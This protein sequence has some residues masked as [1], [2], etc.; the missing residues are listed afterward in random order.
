MNVVTPAINV[1]N[2][3]RNR[4]QSGTSTLK[5]QEICGRDIYRYALRRLESVQDAEDVAA[6]VYAVALASLW[7]PET[8]LRPWLIGVARRKVIDRIRKRDRRKET[9]FHCMSETIQAETSPEAE[10]LRGEA[11]KTIKSL[12]LGLPELQREALL[13][14]IADGLTIRE[15]A[16]AIGKSPS[17]TNSLLARARETLKQKGS[18]YFSEETT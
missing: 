11:A 2:R 7:K 12:V 3:L 9:S 14:Q 16:I 8:D 6:E 1:I 5:L 18:H 15:I 17:A 4:D 13:L 10:V